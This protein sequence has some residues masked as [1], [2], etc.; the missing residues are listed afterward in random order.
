M[1]TLEI[2][3]ARPE[4]EALF[5]LVL[6]LPAVELPTATELEL[7]KQIVWEVPAELESRYTIY[8]SVTGG[9]SSSETSESCDCDLETIFVA[10]C[11]S[12]LPN[13]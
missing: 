12:A 1:P 7:S 13:C 6:D 10:V 8:N 9:S 3:L 11:V 2:D 5:E 4:R